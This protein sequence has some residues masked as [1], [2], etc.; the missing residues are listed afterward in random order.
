[1]SRGSASGQCLVRHTAGL[2]HFSRV[3]HGIGH[4]LDVFVHAHDPV[5]FSLLTITNNG[6]TVR[7]L[8]VFGYNEWVL[9][10]PRDGQQLHV[11][12]EFDPPTG[13]I[14][15]SNAYNQEFAHHVAFACV[16]EKPY[17]AREIGDR[18]SAATVHWRS[19]PRWPKKS[20][21]ARLE[22]PWIRVP[23]S[24]FDWYSHLAKADA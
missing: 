10:P 15:A 24:T 19:R 7:T 18:L 5:K 4:E 6:P 1:M 2:T 22:P 14:F 17:S 13:A 3:R 16:S 23:V 20:S 11:V 8:S 21:Q 9:G 12:T